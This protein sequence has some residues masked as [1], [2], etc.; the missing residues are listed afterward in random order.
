[1]E[2]AVTN[3]PCSRCHH[4][5]N[6]LRQLA[7]AIGALKK[8]DDPEARLALESIAILTKLQE[9]CHVRQADDD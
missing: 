7:V 1:M 6:E 3:E 2:S 4:H 8:I 5:I 9:P